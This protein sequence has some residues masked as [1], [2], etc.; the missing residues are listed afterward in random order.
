MKRV[1]ELS[2]KAEGKVLDITAE[3]LVRERLLEFGIAPGQTIKVL[4][5][6]AFAGPIIVQ[7]GPL[8]LA[9][10]SDEADQVWVE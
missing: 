9:M 5:C 2:E 10:R 4:R 3:P 8:F 6:L 7:V 1:S